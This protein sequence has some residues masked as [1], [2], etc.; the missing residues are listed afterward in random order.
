VLASTNAA[1]ANSFFIL[2]LLSA[3]PHPTSDPRLQSFAT[4]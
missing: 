1:I 3:D 2:N 4:T